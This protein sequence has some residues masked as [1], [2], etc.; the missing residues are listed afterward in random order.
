LRPFNP[1]KQEYRPVTQRAPVDFAANYR[2]RYRILEAEQSSGRRSSGGASKLL[3]TAIAILLIGGGG[4]ALFMSGSG[5][6]GIDTT[7]TGAI[8]NDL[9][10]IGQF[11]GM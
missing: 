4:A 5:T 9:E 6:P 11:E 1:C 8:A 7:I 3:L 10:G 2:S